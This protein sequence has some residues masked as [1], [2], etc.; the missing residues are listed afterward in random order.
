MSMKRAYKQPKANKIDYCY[1]EQVVA[2]S[3]EIGQEQ[4]HDDPYCHYQMNT[5]CTS[6]VHKNTTLCDTNLWSL[7]RGS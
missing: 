1:D 3:Q 6:V 7:R 5:G 2:T 4:K